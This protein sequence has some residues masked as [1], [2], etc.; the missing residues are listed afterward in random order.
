[1]GDNKFLRKESTHLKKSFQTLG[2]FPNLC[3]AGFR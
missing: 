2:D 3:Y 1:M